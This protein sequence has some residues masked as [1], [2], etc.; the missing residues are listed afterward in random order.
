MKGI[1]LAGGSG[2]RLYPLTRVVSKQLL[3]IY[4]KP[5]VY[6]PLTTLMLAG[7]HD[8]LVI[9]TPADLPRFEELR[10]SGEQWGLRFTY[11][12]QPRP[13]GLAQAFVIGREFVGRDNVSLILG[14]NIFYGHGLTQQLQRAA[15]LE[16]GA[17]V[18]GYFVKDPQRYGVVELDAQQ[19]AL[20]IEEKPTQRK[21]NYAVTGLYF[22]DNQV[23]DIAAALRPSR[24]GEL[25]IT[26]VNAE[27]LRRC[28]LRVELMGRGYAWLDT[29]THESLMEASSFIEIIEKRQG[30]KVAC[31]EEIAF[32]MGYIDAAQLVQLAEPMKEN[33]YGQYL[34]R[35]VETGGH[36]HEGD[37][38][39]PAGRPPHR[40]EG[41][42]GCAWLLPGDVPGG[43]LRRGGHPPPLRP[44]QP[45][46]LEEGYPA[47]PSLPGAAR[48]G[49]ACA[50]AAGGGVGRGGGRPP[51]LAHLRHVG[52]RGA[53]RGQPPAGV[54]AP[55]LRPWLLRAERERGL[56]L[57]VHRA[58]LAPGRAGGAVE[59]PGPG[60]PLARGGAAAVPEGRGATA[61]EGRA[62]AAAV[63]RHRRDV[64]GPP[65]GGLRARLNHR[66]RFSIAVGEQAG[67]S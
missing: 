48:A 52:G 49:Q 6:Y 35:L 9:S 36:G 64:N 27:Y 17:T 15:A 8:I 7:I 14:D 47:G 43:P 22:Y 10:G 45:V 32:R 31:P 53:L 37:R 51:R 33:D 24:R 4:D 20:S 18:F 60:H 50:G 41:A 54:G 34:I 26:D 13:E 39:A 59:R 21:S 55:R 29:G 44:G 65:P 61:A 3:P 63:R 23:L 2:T 16:Q 66:S 28:Q 58:V 11:A 62:G 67:V 25:E 40:A 57:Q 38:D 19:R 30:L 56:P 46:A 42:R 12:V 1:I 5:M